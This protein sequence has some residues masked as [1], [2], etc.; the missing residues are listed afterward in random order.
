MRGLEASN[1]DIEQFICQWSRWY[2]ISEIVFTSYSIRW[3]AVPAFQIML[4]IGF[5]DLDLIPE[6][7]DAWMLRLETLN[8]VP[9]L[10]KLY[11]MTGV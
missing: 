8:I 11:H 9:E 3:L 1:I 6:F 10:V 2:Q 7:V 5:Q 4:R